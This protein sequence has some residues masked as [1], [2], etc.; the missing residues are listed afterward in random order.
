MIADEDIDWLLSGEP[1][2]RLQYRDFGVTTSEYM[3]YLRDATHEAGITVTMAR[4]EE[5]PGVLVQAH[6]P[7]EEVSLVKPKIIVTKAKV[8][9]LFCRYKECNE[10]VNIPGSGCGRHE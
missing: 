7:D 8:P 1:V 3:D 6:R 5:P 4:I 10:R 2:L 9:H